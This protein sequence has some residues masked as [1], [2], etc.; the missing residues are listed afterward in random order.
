MPLHDHFREPL[1]S[2]RHWTSFHAAWATYISESFNE[3]LPAGYFAEPVAQFAI[4]IDVATWQDGGH[5]SPATGQSSGWTPS[6]PQLIVPF[7]VPTDVVEVLIYRNDGGPT[8][9][10]AVE[11]ISPSNKDRPESR[12]A[13][14]SKCAAYLHAAVGLAMVDIVTERRAN[15][16]RQLLA[17]VAPEN[18]PSPDSDLYAGAYRPVG[19]NGQASLEVWHE[20]LTIGQRLPTLPLWLRGGLWLS[21]DLEATYADTLRRQRVLPNGPG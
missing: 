6:R 8:L 21:L 16:H 19:P 11:L 20:P 12:E 2:R 14:V 5:V 13:F 9:A 3:R 7:V 1:V 17:R 4:E 10:G 15:L 18:T